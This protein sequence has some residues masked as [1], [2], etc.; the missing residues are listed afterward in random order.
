MTTYRTGR[1][2]GRTLYVQVSDKPS[3]DDLLIGVL[4]T[5]NLAA[6]A[7]YAMSQVPDPVARSI[8]LGE[9]P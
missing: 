7:A 4:D 9:S 5:P 1:K 2:V 6:L 8:V 3:D